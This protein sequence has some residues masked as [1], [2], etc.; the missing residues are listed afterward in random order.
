MNLNQV[1]TWGISLCQKELITVSH[2]SGSLAYLILGLSRRGSRL[3]ILT[4]KIPGSY[5]QKAWLRSIFCPSGTQD[6]L[7]TLRIMGFELL[8]GIVTPIANINCCSN[9]GVMGALSSLETGLWDLWGE[10]TWRKV[11]RLDFTGIRAVQDSVFA[12]SS[13]L[14][15]ISP[16]RS[17]SFP[18][19]II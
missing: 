13:R 1:K 4:A 2:W 12:F 3:V 11:M 6:A 19:L 16:P 8:F 14:R 9:G 15:A 10:G 18:L 7:K 5:Y 17:A